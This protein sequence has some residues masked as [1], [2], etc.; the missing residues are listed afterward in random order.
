MISCFVNADHAGNLVAHCS[1][2]GIIIFCNRAPIF[3]FSKREYTM[4]TST[5]GSEFIAAKIAVE[6][7]E[8]LHYKLRMFGI[9]VDNFKEEAQCDSIP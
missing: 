2:S 5:F 3:W 4:E 8:S 9:P 7:I 1:H 6:L